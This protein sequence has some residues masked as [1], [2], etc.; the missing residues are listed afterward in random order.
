MKDTEQMSPRTGNSD[1]PAGDGHSSKVQPTRSV[2]SAG[3]LL[4]SILTRATGTSGM[5]VP[6]SD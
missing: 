5:E 1:D 2:T 4:S 3:S 6:V